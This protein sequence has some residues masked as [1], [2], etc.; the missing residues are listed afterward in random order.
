MVR[1]LKSAA[2][3]AAAAAGVLL[4]LVVVVYLSARAMGPTAAEREALAVVDAAPV[5]E[6][7]DG[8]AELYTMAHDVPEKE[9]ARVLAQDVSRVAA[10]PPP[11]PEGTDGPGWRSALDDWPPL[12]A[13][14]PSDPAWCSL[15]EPGCL[16]RVRAAQQA[17]AGMLE[18]NAPQLDRAASLARWDYFA[19]PFPPRLDMPIPA[20]QSLTRL[21][22][23][24]AWRFAI[25]ETDAALAGVCAGVAQGRTLIAT[26]DSLIGS[27]IGAALVQGN[28][29]LLADMLAELPRD[30]VLPAQCDSVFALPLPSGTGICRTMLSEGRYVAGGLRSQ[31]TAE[32]A[33]SLA[34]QRAPAWVSRLFFD[35]ERTVARMAPKFAWYCGQQARALLAQDQPLLDPSPLPTRV[36]LQCASNPIGCA[37]ADIAQPAYSDY[38]L[39]L[40]DTDARLRLTAAM[41]WLRAQQGPI[42]EAAV[43]RLP[44]TF[45]SQARPPSLDTNT[46]TLGTAVYGRTEKDSTRDGMWWMPLPSS[47][48]QSAD[49]SSRTGR[50]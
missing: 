22:T 4:L 14:R 3:A 2:A 41:L 28:A 1:I 47:R 15:R 48:I 44:T 24:Y 12:D 33:G 10:L 20:Y 32:I 8:F 37:L 7:L 13:S 9:R 30:R 18:R 26:G 40:Q 38:G 43:T 46:G 45:R 39:R 27:M 36:S 34:D 25:G 50:R 17:Y 11:S 42:D 31:V 19:N 16:E 23:R 29:A 35:P 5:H 21:P 49:V 6:G